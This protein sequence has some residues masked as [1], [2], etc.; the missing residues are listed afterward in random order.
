MYVVDV[1]STDRFIDERHAHLQI[2]DLM[3][4]APRGSSVRLVVGRTWP[5]FSAAEFMEPAPY[6][7]QLVRDHAVQLEGEVRTVRAWMAALEGVAA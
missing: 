3:R 7:V 4:V 5:V 2:D 1:S 6:W